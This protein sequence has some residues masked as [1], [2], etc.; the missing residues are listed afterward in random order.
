MFEIKKRFNDLRTRFLSALLLIP[1]GIWAVTAQSTLSV[2]VIIA[3]VAIALGEW[4]YAV[5]QSKRDKAPNAGKSLRLKFIVGLLTA[6]YIIAGGG[7][8]I[9]LNTAYAVKVSIGLLIITI[10]ADT[11]AYMTGKMIGGPKLAPRISPNKTVSGLAGGLFFG[12]VFGALYF[13]YP[14]FLSAPDYFA[15]SLLLALAAQAGDLGQSYFK[16]VFGVKDTSALIPGHG[17]VFDRLDGLLGAALVGCF[18][19]GFLENA[20]S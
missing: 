13:A 4:A 3:V 7:A 14:T 19:G 12:A 10:A 5:F 9:Y 20:A 18:F 16:R 8:F 1:F 17:G 15:P 11:G 2:R 6:L